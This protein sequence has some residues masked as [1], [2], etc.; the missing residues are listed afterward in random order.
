[1]GI[2][3]EIFN[4][5]NNRTDKQSR[6]TLGEILHR[7][8]VENIF[9]ASKYYTEWLRDKYIKEVEKSDEEE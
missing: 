4:Y 8:N 3:T 9:I 6:I 5:C 2:R 7:T 1:M